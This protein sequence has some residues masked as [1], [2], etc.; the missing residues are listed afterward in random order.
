MNRRQQRRLDAT[1]SRGGLQVWGLRATL[2]ASLYIGRRQRCP[3]HGDERIATFLEEV[4]S[5]RWTDGRVRGLRA[6]LG[7]PPPPP[8]RPKKPPKD[9]PARRP[10]Y[11]AEECLEEDEQ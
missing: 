6:A 11:I 5:E 4:T 10:I 2:A 8:H 3:Y 1:A 9:Y 7:P